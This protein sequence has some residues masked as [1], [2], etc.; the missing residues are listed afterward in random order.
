MFDSRVAGG[1][2][3]VGGGGAGTSMQVD[4]T[5]DGNAYTSFELGSG[6]LTLIKGLTFLTE[7][8]AVTSSGDGNAVTGYTYANAALVL[9]KEATFLTDHITVTSSG[10]GN[11]VT[12]YTYANAAL[13]LNKDKTMVDCGDVNQTIGGTKTFT[14]TVW[15]A[16]HRL[17]SDERLKNFKANILL[18]LEQIANAPSVEFTWKGDK[19]GKVFGGT[20]AQY[21]KSIAPWAV[22][23]A[24]TGFMGVNY[25]TLALASAIQL[26]REVVALKQEVNDLKAELKSMKETLNAVVSA[27][28]N[29]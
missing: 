7:H 28:K 1:G 25:E 15:A 29:G 12:G 3:V 14:G 4:E 21:W 13:T 20:Y 22:D 17:S 6:I 5:G 26:A 8:I 2:S 9:K 27:L 10:D 18:G 16:D 11:V 19:S 23:E 24:N